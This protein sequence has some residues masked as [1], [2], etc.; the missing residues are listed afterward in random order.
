MHS[1]IPHLIE[2]IK[3]A[4]R[5]EIPEE[6]N[7][8]QTLEEH[9]EE[10]E[11]WVREDEPEHTLGYHCGL[12][13]ENFPPP[14]QLTEK[15][16]KLIRK[17]FERMMYSWNVDIDLP[18]KLPVDFAYKMIVETLDSK[19]MIVTNGFTGFDFCSGNAPDCIFKEYCPCLKHWNNPIHFTDS[20]LD[21]I[22]TEMENNWK[23]MKLKEDDPKG[24]ED[25]EFGIPW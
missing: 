11:A 2:D 25:D 17:E 23:K 7:T 22:K 4:H 12:R 20:E 18:K 24:D 5:V 9:F 13:S 3:A 19:I 14:E 1:Y 6:E 10:I 21:K 16:M 15:E 8:P